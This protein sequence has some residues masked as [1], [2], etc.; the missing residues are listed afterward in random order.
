[1]N[2]IITVFYDGSTY[3]LRWL[4]GVFSA[5]RQ[6]FEHGFRIELSSRRVLFERKFK[7]EHF[8][9][10]ILNNEFDIVF[11][12][13]HHSSEFMRSFEDGELDRL[14][15]FLRKKSNFLVWLDTADS[16]GTCAFEVLPYVDKYLK[17]QLLCDVENYCKPIWGGRIFC[18]YYHN[19]T[20]IEDDEISNKHYSTLSI[21]DASKLGVSWNVGLGDLF[22]SNKLTHLILEARPSIDF[23]QPSVERLYDVYYRGSTKSPIAGYQR[24]KCCELMNSY[25]Q[26]L[27]CPDPT[28]AVPKRQYKFEMA[29]TR[30]VLSPFGWGEI[31]TRDFECFV[32][33]AAL[34]KP[35]MGHLVTYPDC[36]LSGETYISLDWDF[37]NFDDVAHRVVENPDE[38]LGIA[39]AGQQLYQYHLSNDGKEDFIAHLLSELNPSSKG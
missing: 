14:L 5:Q 3:T 12:A 32:N 39:E 11:L 7:K 18:E 23:I 13:F 28:E 21:K 16:T 31:C 37:S 9:Q 27:R 36:Y 25:G 29:S 34:I 26:D 22:S 20:G 35:D 15:S 4:K 30:S 38:L 6:L 2:R 24:A 1:M 8:K 19:I 10:A 33:G 17:K